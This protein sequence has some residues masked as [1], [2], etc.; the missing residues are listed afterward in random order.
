MAN[1]KPSITAEQTMALLRN[2]DNVIS[3]CMIILNSTAGKIEQDA[4]QRKPEGPRVWH[5]WNAEAVLEIA[6]LLGVD[7]S[8]LLP[9]V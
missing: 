8:S 6:S 3:K 1:K 5:Q 4:E 9:P 7:G 2:P